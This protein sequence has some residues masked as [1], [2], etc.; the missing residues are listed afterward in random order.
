[1]DEFVSAVAEQP[2]AVW[3]REVELCR[4]FPW[5]LN[6]PGTSPTHSPIRVARAVRTSESLQ[7]H[8]FDPRQ[9]IM[10]RRL[11]RPTV[12]DSGVL[13]PRVLHLGDGGHR[14]AL[15]HRSGGLLEP[16]MHRID[17]RPS[18]VIDNTAILAPRTS[19]CSE[20]EYAAFLSL[21]FL[22]AACRT[23]WTRSGRESSTH[24][25]DRLAEL[26]SP[27]EGAVAGRGRAM[28]AWWDRYSIRRR[29]ADPEA[30][31]DAQDRAPDPLGPNRGRRPGYRGGPPR[32]APSAASGLAQGRWRRAPPARTGLR[33]PRLRRRTPAVRDQ[34]A[35]AWCSTSRPR[36]RCA[37]RTTARCST[38]S[39]SAPSTCCASTVRASRQQLSSS[40]RSVTRSCSTPPGPRRAAP[41]TRGLGLPRPGLPGPVRGL[42]VRAGQPAALRTSP[43]ER[44]RPSWQGER[45][46]QASRSSSSRSFDTATMTPLTAA[47]LFWA[48]RNQLYFELGLDR[49]DDVLLVSYDAFAAQPADEMRRLC[50][51]VGVAYRPAL[52]EHVDRR[53]SHGTKPLEIDPRVRALATEVHERLRGRARGP[54]PPV[55]A[56]TRRRPGREARLRSGIAGDA[57]QQ[58]AWWSA[59]CCCGACTGPPTQG[60]S[61]D[62]H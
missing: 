13:V 43:Q 4:F 2:Y 48:I 58:Q 30:A 27:G 51:F 5:V 19:V 49:R 24:C 11:A 22:D 20:Q 8:G 47:V 39:A 9:P 12:S 38:V 44:A 45:L 54:G 40:S 46:P 62:Q 35:H 55:A 41:G 7:Q 23:R 42:E 31:P 60:P 37:T 52:D 26:E 53:V 34:H 15:V 10:L 33:R 1:M 14:L 16:S 17:P 50:G 28:S 3:F 29:S 61:D 57:R 56:R 18:K 25:P 32:P 21:G 59:P 6:D 36:S